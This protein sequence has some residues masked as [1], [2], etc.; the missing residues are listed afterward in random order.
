LRRIGKQTTLGLKSDVQVADGLHHRR[1]LEAGATD[2]LKPEQWPPSAPRDEVVRLVAG[3]PLRERFVLRQS[4]RERVW[5]AEGGSCLFTLDEVQVRRGREQVG[6][7]RQLEVELRRG[8]RSLLRQVDDV[9]SSSLLVRHERRSKMALA[10]GMVRAAAPIQAEEAFG[11]AGRRILRRHLERMLER[12]GPTRM[13]DR[14]ALK[15][16]RVATRRMRATWRLF[17]GAY[18]A[19]AAKRYVAELRGV[20][21]RLGAVRDLDVL[22]EAL[23]EDEALAPL[24]EAWRER[25]ELC[26]Q[27]LQA[28]LRSSGYDQ[29]VNDYREFTEQAA[30][31]DVELAAL[32]VRDLAGSRVWAAYERVRAYE[33]R[34]VDPEVATLHALRIDGKRLRYAI[35]TFA[36]L[37]G[38][39]VASELLPR[40]THLQDHLGALNDAQVGA[41]A[42]TD[43]LAGDGATVAPPARRAARAYATGQQAEI[44]RLQRTFRRAWRPVAGADF[45]RR[46]AGAL[47]EI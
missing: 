46:L 35:E 24:A 32:R 43:W 45:R 5:Q 38:K 7:L 8:D 14:L 9:V 20:A 12:E 44:E 36:P 13:G 11:L 6:L 25:R 4:R 40:M 33:P 3:R 1:E 42:V 26:W 2:S 18:R 34:L 37:L 39:G 27:Q 15:Q 47:A 30:E 29:F 19:R 10:A 22:L 21:R 23:P 17:D 16:M 31:D 41:S 28:T